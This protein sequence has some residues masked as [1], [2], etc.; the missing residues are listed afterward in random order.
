VGSGS[1]TL[2]AGAVSVLPSVVFRYTGP[3]T[4]NKNSA[5]DA[6]ATYICT[7][8]D[9]LGQSSDSSPITVFAAP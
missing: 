5:S 3:T 7:V 4:T 2:G 6:R 1:S 9:A 8:T